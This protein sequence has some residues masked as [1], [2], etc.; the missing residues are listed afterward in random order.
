MPRQDYT[1]R[2]ATD[3]DA[4]ALTE[5]KV[6]MGDQHHA[7]DPEVWAEGD[8]TADGWRREFAEHLR[9]ENVR[10]LVAESSS[11][12]CVGLVTCRV[13]EA[14]YE[15]AARRAGLIGELIIH[16]AHQRRG[17][18]ARLAEAALEALG[19]LGADDVT[20]HVAVRNAQAVRFYERLG[21]RIIMHRMFMRLRPADG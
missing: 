5:L 21:F 13:D 10:V 15:R 19:E 7:Y 8:R 3:V 6:R 1:I 14:P 18:G 17:L 12:E 11:G 20:L 2:P 9:A 16:P 4:D